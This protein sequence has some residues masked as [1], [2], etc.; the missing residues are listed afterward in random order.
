MAADVGLSLI[1]PIGPGERAWQGMLPVLAR[2]P[3]TVEILFV[4]TSSMDRAEA[5]S[6]ADHS[7]SQRVRWEVVAPGR[8]QQLNHGASIANQPYLWFLHADSRL[9]Y[10]NWAGLVDSVAGHPDAL[11][12]FDLKFYDGPL[13]TAFNSFGVWL[14]SHLFKLPFG[15]QGFCISR[16]I[17]S[18]LGGFATDVPYGEDH[19]LVWRALQC[20]IPVK[21]CGETLATSARKYRKNGWM[22]TTALHNY[23]TLRQAL[24]QLGKFCQLRLGMGR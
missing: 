9:T 10:R 15:D 23:L 3:H 14:R 16:R 1:V 5:E 6:L 11:H 19:L 8:A 18:E 7:L 22:Q 17:F 2:L 24:P 4:A 12:Y 13:L 20:G 21:C